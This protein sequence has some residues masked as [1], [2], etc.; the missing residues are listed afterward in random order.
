MPVS[1]VIA[2][3]GR[4]DPSVVNAQSCCQYEDEREG[5]LICSFSS[6][7]IRFLVGFFKM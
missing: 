6:F 4:L 2:F 1:F 5:I 7:L 3:I